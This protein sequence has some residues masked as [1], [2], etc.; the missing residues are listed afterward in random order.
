MQALCESNLFDPPPLPVGFKLSECEEL[1]PLNPAVQIPGFTL[2]NPF[3]PYNPEYS[4]KFY[5]QYKAGYIQMYE[6]EHHHDVGAS[7]RGDKHENGK[8]RLLNPDNKEVKMTF[9]KRMAE[10]FSPEEWCGEEGSLFEELLHIYGTRFEEI[11]RLMCGAKTASQVHTH[12]T[13]KWAAVADFV[14]QESKRKTTCHLCFE[15]VDT[16]PKKG[17][18]A[19]RDRLV[20]CG[21]C[22]RAYHVVCLN[23]RPVS[24]TEPWFCSDECVNMSML[25]CQLCGNA[26]NDEKMLL[27]DGCD[28]GYH[29]FCLNPPLNEIPEGEWNCP[30]CEGAPAPPPLKVDLPHSSDEPLPCP[31]TAYQFITTYQGGSTPRV[32][33]SPNTSFL[34]ICPSVT[35]PIRTYTTARSNSAPAIF[36]TT[37][38]RPIKDETSTYAKEIPETTEPTEPTEHMD[39]T[40]STTQPADI[41]TETTKEVERTEKADNVTEDTKSDTKMEDTHAE[42]PFFIPPPPPLPVVRKKGR[43]PKNT[44]PQSPST[45]RKSPSFIRTLSSPQSPALKIAVKPVCFSF[46]FCSIGL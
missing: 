41:P 13:T 40:E 2:V 32:F 24:T 9:S 1:E 4:R 16:K 38:D 26:E 44:P 23:P 7:P 28:R 37:P 5:D 3:I 39:Q 46:A 18:R 8:G 45:P 34:E 17:P 20:V 14:S 21:G 19:A 15:T 12:F 11:S 27:C 6:I 30:Q 43:P 35:L 29:M 25:Q 42:K 33:R 22:E 10:L 31:H 36:A